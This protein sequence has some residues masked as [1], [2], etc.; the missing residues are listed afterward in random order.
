MGNHDSE[1]CNDTKMYLAGGSWLKSMDYILAAKQKQRMWRLMERV[2]SEFDVDF[3]ITPTTGR[4]PAMRK[5]GDDKYM[6]PDNDFSINVM[7]FAPLGNLIGLPAVSVPIGV[8]T[9]EDSGVEFPVSLQIYG[10][11]WMEA[12]ILELARMIEKAVGKVEYKKEIVY[13]Y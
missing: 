7:S 5:P 1:I 4:L 12:E 13:S 9:S 10:K 11:W 8:S 3:I 2:F 6:F